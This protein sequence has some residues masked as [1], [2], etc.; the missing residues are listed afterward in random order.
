MI[1]EPRTHAQN[2]ARTQQTEE[3]YMPAAPAKRASRRTVARVAETGETPKTAK[4]PSVNKSTRCGACGHCYRDHC[5]GHTWHSPERL[6]R[7]IGSNTRPES[8]WPSDDGW[9]SCLTLHCTSGVFENGHSHW[10]PCQ[11]FVNPHTGKVVV[12]RPETLPDTP[13]AECSHPKKHHCR[14]GAIS[15]VVDGV[16]RVCRHYKE[17]VQAGMNGQPACPNTACAEV[18][19]DEIFCSCVKFV[20]PYRKPPRRR[21]K[22]ADLPLIPPAAADG[23]ESRMS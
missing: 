5:E 22:K 3:L 21:S 8:P 1:Y 18:N 17:W 10:C 4:T 14:K 2:Q 23:S 11:G 7:V 13:C 20:S 12:W 9:F 19:K 16:A 6:N 15:I